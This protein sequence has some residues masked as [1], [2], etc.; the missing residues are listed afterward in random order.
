MCCSCNTLFLIL[1]MGR[2]DDFNQPFHEPPYRR[3]QPSVVKNAHIQRLMPVFQGHEADL[4]HR[5][6]TVIGQNA[7]ADT[8]FHQFQ[9]RLGSVDGAYNVFFCTVRPLTEA[10]LDIVVESDLRQLSQLLGREDVGACQRMLC[11]ES[12]GKIP[13]VQLAEMQASVPVCGIDDGHVQLFLTNQIH[14]L[15]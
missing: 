14:Q 7:D 4:W 8:C 11:A 2:T 10:L 13:L 6:D 9:C 15:F 1:L 12:N 3:F 5:P